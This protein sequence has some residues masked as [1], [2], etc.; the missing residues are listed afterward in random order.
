VLQKHLQCCG[1]VNEFGHQFSGQPTLSERDKPAAL[2]Q[3]RLISEDRFFQHVQKMGGALPVADC[4][5][6]LCEDRYRFLVAFFALLIRG[7]HAVLP[8]SQTERVIGEL[9]ERYPSAYL[10]TDP[11]NSYDSDAKSVVVA[12]NIDDDGRNRRMRAPAFGSDQVAAVNFTSGSTGLPVGHE[13]SWYVFRKGAEL[14]LES[15]AL[16]HRSW[17]VVATVPPQH[18]YGLETSIFWPLFS[19]L[20]MDAGRPFF[21]EDIR[22]TLLDSP[23][24]CLLVSTPCHLKA[25]IESGVRWDNAA[26]VLSSTAPMSEDL[27][28]RVEEAFDAPLYE[29]FG[30]TETLSFAWRRPVE[31]HRWRLYSGMKLKECD[32]HVLLQGGHLPDPVA[33]DDLLKIHSNDEFS[34]I[35]R[36]SGIIKIGGKRSS[37]AELNRRLTDIDGIMD[38]LFFTP[39]DDAAKH[40]L[41]AIVVSELSRPVILRELRRSLDG[42]FLPRPILYVDRIPRNAVGKVV[43]AELERLIAARTE[44]ASEDIGCDGLRSGQSTSPAGA[45]TS[46]IARFKRG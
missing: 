17:T 5:L 16:K 35:E 3:G 1:A 18:M 14:A 7:Q 39:D 28:E 23:F 38:G 24:P 11:E 9:I 8:S 20:V 43:K 29:L 40:R 30:S 6:N 41:G 34:I 27:A 36:R 33:L 19:D 12:P 13:K 15:L 37:I 25:C 45:R 21:P 26:R 42:L 46:R 2:W 10:L 44:S 22:R 32:G 4:G 31:Q